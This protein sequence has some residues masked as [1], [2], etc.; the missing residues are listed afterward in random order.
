[1]FIGPFIPQ[2]GNPPQFSKNP[3]PQ[4][5]GHLHHIDAT[6]C[7]D[8]LQ[9]WS[10]VVFIEKKVIKVVLIEVSFSA[11]WIR[12]TKISELFPSITLQSVSLE[13]PIA[14]VNEYKISVC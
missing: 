10:L 14:R 13:T 6:P 4:T 12:P 3:T 9:K 2:C 11:S 1:M 7:F 8:L 5:I